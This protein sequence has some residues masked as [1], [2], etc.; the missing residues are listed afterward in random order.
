MYFRQAQK[1]EA[2]AIQLTRSF[3]DEIKSREKNALSFDIARRN[4]DHVIC[5]QPVIISIADEGNSDLVR[6]KVAH[7]AE[8]G[9][10]ISCFSQ[11]CVRSEITPRLVVYSRF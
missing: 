6:R 5:P 9:A 3:I 11:V 2:L 7:R 1:D 10:R 8:Y 4:L